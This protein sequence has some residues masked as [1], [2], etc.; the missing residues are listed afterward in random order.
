M[1]TVTQDSV[2]IQT[3]CSFVIEFVIP[4]FFKG[5]TCFKWHTT[6]HQKLQTVF[7]ASGLYAHMVISRDSVPTQPWQRLVTIWAYKP[8]AA[9]TV[10]SS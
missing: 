3:R 2:E 6:H 9:N 10:W 1:Y 5:S 8:E 4:K 7:A